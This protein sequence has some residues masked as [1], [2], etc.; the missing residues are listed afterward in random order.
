MEWI[1][2][3]R[4]VGAARHHG[5]GEPLVERVDDRREVMVVVGAVASEHVRDSGGPGA[6]TQPVRMHQT[7]PDLRTVGSRVRAAPGAGHGAEMPAEPS[8]FGRPATA[9]TEEVRV[10]RP[11][12]LFRSASAGIED[13]SAAPPLARAPDA[14]AAPGPRCLRHL[15]RCRQRRLTTW[16]RLTRSR[17]AASILGRGVEQRQLVG[18][19][20]RRS[21]VRIRPPQPRPHTPEPRVRPP[22]VRLCPAHAHDPVRHRM[23]EVSVPG[24][25][26]R[27][28]ADR[29]GAPDGEQDEI[30]ERIA[31]RAQ[32]DP[33]HLG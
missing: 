8:A 6:S 16:S 13:R 17:S 32:R 33:R 29:H 14:E 11:P 3:A 27:G 9:P 2:P 31:A 10:T 21:A 25:R 7:H 19:I 20:T 12:R 1:D 5:A 26:G 22:G 28:E 18:L 24:E 4:R 15:S 23:P 30:A